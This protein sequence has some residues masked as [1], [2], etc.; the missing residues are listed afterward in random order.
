LREF[1]LRQSGDGG[2]AAR[3][4]VRNAAA[5]DFP[6]ICHAAERFGPRLPGLRKQQ[7]DA[8]IDAGDLPRNENVYNRLF[9]LR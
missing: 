1:S 8:H 5:T 9:F 6:Q 3:G 7:I 4:S 2:V